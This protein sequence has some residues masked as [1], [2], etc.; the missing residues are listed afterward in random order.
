MRCT[1]CGGSFNPANVPWSVQY[2]LELLKE[3]IEEDP[4]AII[5]FYGGEPLLNTPFIRWVMDNVKAR[6]FVIQTNG[7]LAKMLEKDYW[8]RFDAILLS[9]DGIEE[10]TD[11]YRGKGVYRGVLKAASWLREIGYRGDLIARMTVTES[12]NIYRDAI[13]L[14]S[15]PY[16][17]HIHWQLDVIWSNRWRDFIGW[18]KENYLPGLRKLANLWLNEMKKGKILGIA[19]FLGIV[20]AFFLGY[21]SNPPCGAGSKAFA[22]STDGRILACPI[23]VEEK[24][25]FI[26]KLGETSIRDITN[27]VR[28]GKPCMNC[29]Y[30]VFCGGRCLYAYKERLWGEKGFKL[31]CEITRET[32]NVVLEK[33]PEILKLLDENIISFENIIYPPFNNTIEVIP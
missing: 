13:H 28:I 9:I 29:S 15:I 31:V 22:I 3:F 26:G 19:P 27:R 30:F 7:L 14:L 10:L 4:E 8:S 6:H 25:A 20:K 12:S 32:I 2:D 5:A 33:I 18:I 1:Y 23:A 16:F 21:E 11:H 17:D 24:W